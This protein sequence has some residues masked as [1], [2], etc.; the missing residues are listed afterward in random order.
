M[1][2]KKC[3]LAVA[4]VL[5]AFLSINMNVTAGETAIEWAPFI[6]AS[7]VTDELLI[8]KA[9][10]VNSDFLIKQK[11]F[12][13]RELIKK[14]ENEYADVVYWET[15]SDA[16]TAGEKVST[17]VTCGEYFELMKMGEKAGEGF[18]HYSII[19]SWKL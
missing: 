3:K 19:K 10:D 6:K 9:N 14:D 5:L 7:G 18:S 13:K 11:G 8:A 4:G 17:C 16:V 2:T 12:I 15:K 1:K